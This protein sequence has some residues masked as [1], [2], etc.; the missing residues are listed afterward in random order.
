MKI[1]PNNF[2]L[3]KTTDEDLL[4]KRIEGAED[5]DL[6]EVCKDFEAVFVHMMLKEMRKT[7]PDSGFIEKSTGIRIFEDMFDEEISNKI[8]D[9]EE[10]GIGIARMLYDQF[11]NKNVVKI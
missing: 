9:S 1:L 7:V 5:E 3:Q 10:D 2:M 8:A 11:Q 6:M 4:Q